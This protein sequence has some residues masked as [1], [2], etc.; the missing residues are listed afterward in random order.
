MPAKLVSNL[1][2]KATVLIAMVQ[3]EFGKECERGSLREG[4]ARGERAVAEWR[5]LSHREAR[6][7]MAGWLR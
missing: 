6:I 1:K 2:R 4:V 7:R 5:I 3:P